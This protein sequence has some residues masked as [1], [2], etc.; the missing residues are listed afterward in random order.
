MEPEYSYGPI[1]VSDA[2]LDLMRLR[3]T[4][5]FVDKL[6]GMG[7]KDDAIAEARQALRQAQQVWRSGRPECEL[8]ACAH[9]RASLAELQDRYR[10]LLWRAHTQLANLTHDLAHAYE[11]A[12]LRP[13]L[14]TGL[15]LLGKALA[16]AQRHEEAACHL[17]AALDANPF[18]REA[19]LALFQALTQ[20]QNESGRRRLARERW[21]ELEEGAGRLEGE[22][23]TQVD[24]R[25]LRARALLARR[26]FGAA[27]TLLE[28]IVQGH[29]NDLWPL[30]ILSYVLLQEGQDLP[31]A[32]KVLR[33]ILALD[34]NNREAQ[35][36]LAVLLRQMGE[37]RAA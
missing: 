20:L 7:K 29:P 4:L 33:D 3:A 36:N 19:A 23:K 21:P 2:E 25:V 31:A 1:S 10:L 34:P 11:V 15:V 8:A 16:G 27:R 32:E 6:A 26:E 22:T 5:D 37:D 24:G 13:N 28:E 9:P 35:S 18:D 17:R 14:P 30:V 12:L